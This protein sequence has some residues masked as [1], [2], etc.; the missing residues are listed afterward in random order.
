MRV[1]RTTIAK[2]TRTNR[3]HSHLRIQEERRQLRD[4]IA[5]LTPYRPGGLEELAARGTT[6]FGTASRSSRD[7][8]FKR[9]GVSGWVGPM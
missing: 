9:T 4:L 8:R 6:A 2:G 5:T 3:A 1:H 7:D